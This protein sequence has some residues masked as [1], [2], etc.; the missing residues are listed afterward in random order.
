MTAKYNRRS[1]AVTESYPEYTVANAT[2]TGT[3][4]F[5]LPEG[6]A[7]FTVNGMEF[8]SP[9]V[10]REVAFTYVAEDQADETA[11]VIASGDARVRAIEPSTRNENQIG[12]IYIPMSSYINANDATATI[13]GC[14]AAGNPIANGGACSV[15]GVGNHSSSEIVVAYNILYDDRE[16]Y[17]TYS[18]LKITV[19]GVK[20]YPGDDDVATVTVLLPMEDLINS[21]NEHIYT[22]RQNG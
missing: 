5:T 13:V 10:T 14:D 20:T 9:K 4:A 18:K 3:V 15:T 11:S 6:Y 21:G 7:K 1:S 19:M 8:T 2:A 16:I 22:R 12:E 17:K